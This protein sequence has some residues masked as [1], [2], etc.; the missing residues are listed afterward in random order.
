VQFSNRPLKIG[1]REAAALPVGHRLF[2]VQTIEVDRH[3]DIFAGE[4]FRKFLKTVAPII[5][6]DRA[7][8]LSIFQGAIVCPGMHFK[9]SGAFRTTIAK[10]PMGPPTFEIAAA[11]NTREPYIWEFQCAVHPSATRPLRRPHI[12]IG[13]II[14]RNEDDRS[15]NRTQS[16]RRQVVK[17]AGPVEQERSCEI[18]VSLAKELFDQPRG[19]GKTQARA[20]TP[21]ISYRKAR[22]VVRPRVIEIEMK[23]AIFQDQ[24]C[25]AGKISASA[26]FAVRRFSSASVYPGLRRSAS[27]NWTTA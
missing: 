19:R 7:L 26:A 21:R 17:V 18:P 8:P 10:D 22:R 25:A 1:D 13:M 9:N 3:V 12:P 5:T 4:T 23:R 24:R 6:Q 27:V 2:D 15:G 11:P 16:E 14:E 20:P